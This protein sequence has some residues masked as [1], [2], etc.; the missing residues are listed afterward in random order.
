MAYWAAT[1]LEANHERV[2]QFFLEQT[3]YEVHLPLVR[4]RTSRTRAKRVSALFPGYIFVRVEQLWRDI[5]RLPGVI[6]PVMS[7]EEPAHVPDEVI[8]EIRSREQNGF[9]ELPKK[10]L[11]P[12]DRVRI[13]EGLLAGRR[14]RYE[15]DMRKH[16]R[17][18]LQLL[19]TERQVQVSPDAVEQV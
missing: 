6:R 10:G 2:A 8:T 12:G 13:I 11:K 18:L 7:G 14:G 9:V 1:R 5:S 19:G 15:G 17:V 3:G 16:V 4:W